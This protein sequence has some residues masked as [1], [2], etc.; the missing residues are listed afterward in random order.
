MHT[1]K[2][3]NNGR[4]PLLGHDGSSLFFNSAQS[5]CRGSLA[6]ENLATQRRNLSQLVTFLDP[7]SRDHYRSSLEARHRIA[8]LVLDEVVPSPW[9]QRPSSASH[10]I[11]HI[12]AP[13][14]T[15][16][17]LRDSVRGLMATCRCPDGCVL[18][19][20]RGKAPLKHLQGL[21]LVAYAES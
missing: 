8:D 9:Q 21:S 20:T 11:K 16:H 13:I 6:P 2:D 5:R 10:P 3:H 1:K 19:S 17:D 4:E 12:L 15:L 14:Q 18:M 7:L